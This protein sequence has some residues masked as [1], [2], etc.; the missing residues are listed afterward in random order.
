MRR[1]TGAPEQRASV[2][3][4]FDVQC[5][6]RGS[7][8][9]ACRPDCPLRAATARW[10]VSTER[11]GARSE[12][13]RSFPIPHVA[14]NERLNRLVANLGMRSTK[15]FGRLVAQ[16]LEIGSSVVRSGQVEVLL[17]PAKLREKIEGDRLIEPLDQPSLIPA[18]D[19]R[20]G[21]TG[22]HDKCVAQELGI[23]THISR[24]PADANAAPVRQIWARCSVPDRLRGHAHPPGYCS[25][26][27]RS[28]GGTGTTWLNSR[29]C[30]VPPS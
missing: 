11:R 3:C 20:H 15:V 8:D 24:L 25:Q 2:A 14:P 22:P 27:E 26:V 7:R 6:G 19:R 16:R 9:L 1:L 10:I 21:L 29:G 17:K 30:Q 12:D 18:R 13:M 5:S 4:S 28:S 23:R